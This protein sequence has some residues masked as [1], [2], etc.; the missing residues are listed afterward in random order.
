MIDILCYLLTTMKRR[1]SIVYLE[2]ELKLNININLLHA[3]CS[4][5][6]LNISGEI[7]IMCQFIAN[8]DI[9]NI[10]ELHKLLIVIK[11]NA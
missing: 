5:Q 2:N 1:N 7:Y 11:L 10:A 9:G 3:L 8:K 6:K 4:T